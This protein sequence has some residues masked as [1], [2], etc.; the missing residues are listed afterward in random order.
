MG[1]KTERKSKFVDRLYFCNKERKFIHVKW[2]YAIDKISH[3][4][5][6]DYHNKQGHIKGK[7]K[8]PKSWV[9]LGWLP[10]G[11]IIEIIRGKS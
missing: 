9:E 8:T 11:T 1:N 5:W 7:L 6:S 2:D 4:W 3:W 10:E